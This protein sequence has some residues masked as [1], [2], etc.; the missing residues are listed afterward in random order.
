MEIVFFILWFICVL[1]C[2][3]IIPISDRVE[4]LNDNSCFKKWWRKHIA[5]WSSY[6]KLK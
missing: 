5:D 4:K 2:I 1:I 3:T 6:N